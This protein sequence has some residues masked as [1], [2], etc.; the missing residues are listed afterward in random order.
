MLPLVTNMSADTSA[1]FRKE[2]SLDEQKGQIE[3]AL[4]WYLS[5]DSDLTDRQKYLPKRHGRQ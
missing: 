3:K 5:R 4:T 2:L 1:T